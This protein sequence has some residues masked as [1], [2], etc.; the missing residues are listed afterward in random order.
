METPYEI[1]SNVARMKI[2]FIIASTLLIKR[3][4]VIGKEILD[5][6]IPWLKALSTVRLER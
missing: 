1:H 5:F 4:E 6:I 3:S 2:D